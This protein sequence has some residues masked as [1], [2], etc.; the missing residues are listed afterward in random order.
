[1]TIFIY[2]AILSTFHELIPYTKY[3]S[4]DTTQAKRIGHSETNWP[5]SL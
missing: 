5:A 4:N 3:Y 2:I 1:M